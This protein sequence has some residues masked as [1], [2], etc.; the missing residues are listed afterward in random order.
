M[1]KL[2][3]RQ[4]EMLTYIRTYIRTNGYPPTMREIGGSMGIKSPN[5]VIEILDRLEIKGR[6]RRKRNCQRAIAVLAVPKEATN[7]R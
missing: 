6:I 2:T 3:A 1:K 7:V 4:S 5:G